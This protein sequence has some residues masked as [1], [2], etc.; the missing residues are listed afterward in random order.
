MERRD[1]KS[2]KKKKNEKQEL[3]SYDEVGELELSIISKVQT[4]NFNNLFKVQV[5]V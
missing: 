4:I 5:Y 2:Q 1:S 3:H